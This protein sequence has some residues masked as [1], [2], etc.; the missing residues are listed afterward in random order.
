METWYFYSKVAAT[1]ISNIILIH[2]RNTFRNLGRNK[3]YRAVSFSG[4]FLVFI[5][6]RFPLPHFL[7]PNI[8]ARHGEITFFFVLSVGYVDNNKVSQQL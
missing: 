8:P 4:V 6:G 2:S 5:F 1:F 3:R 7:S